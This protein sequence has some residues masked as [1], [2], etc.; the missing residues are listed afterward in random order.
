[1]VKVDNYEVPEG[2]YYSNDFAWA[3]VE[4]GKVRMGINPHKPQYEPDALDLT[5]KLPI[6][7]SAGL[8][9]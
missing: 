8:T 1:M 2:L 6:C 4:G 5:P 7:Y 3:K 9:V